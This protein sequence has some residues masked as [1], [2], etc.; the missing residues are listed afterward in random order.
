MNL[1]SL[2]L[3]V[4]W[5][6]AV[7]AS[8]PSPSGCL[9]TNR[10]GADCS[11]TSDVKSMLSA[12]GS[13]VPASCAGGTWTLDGSLVWR[14]LR[15]YVWNLGTDT[16]RVAGD[17]LMTDGSSTVHWMLS[18]QQKSALLLADRQMTLSGDIKAT[19]LDIGDQSDSPAYL[20]IK[21]A[22]WKSHDFS[23]ALNFE[24]QLAASLART[25]R[26]VKSSNVHVFHATN[27]QIE[28]RRIRNDL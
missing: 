12:I 15:Y 27:K 7:F 6:F 23:N 4:T 22:E 18:S 16:V 13:T 28:L 24:P 19:L 2:F 25:W 1:S 26:V 11:C 17:I 5:P 10:F 3:L 8:Q 21:I 9:V 14:G 20:S